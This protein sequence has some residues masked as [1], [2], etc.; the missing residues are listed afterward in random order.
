MVRLRHVGDDGWISF[1]YIRD[2]LLLVL[3]GT[4][5]DLREEI[6][7]VVTRYDT[8]IVKI[9]KNAFPGH[10]VAVMFH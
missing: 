9:V 4:A 7:C 10:H 2:W 5:A 3:G 1:L 8:N 6:A